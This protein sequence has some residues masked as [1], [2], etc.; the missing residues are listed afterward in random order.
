MKVL[1]CK[2]SVRT[3]KLV[4]VLA[5]RQWR[6]AVQP[7]ELF[8]QDGGPFVPGFVIIRQQQYRRAVRKRLQNGRDFR[9]VAAAVHGTGAEAQFLGGERIEHALYYEDRLA[10][11]EL[12][13][14]K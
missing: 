6:T 1:P 5:L 13:R 10:A 3:E 2:C 8:R 11:G 4:E 14:L 9:S 7:R 12:I